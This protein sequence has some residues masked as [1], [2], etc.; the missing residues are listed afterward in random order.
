[1]RDFDTT[2]DRLECPHAGS[3]DYYDPMWSITAATQ[4]DKLS[5]DVECNNCHGADHLMFDV[6]NDDCSGRTEFDVGDEFTVNSSLRGPRRT[7]KGDTGKITAIADNPLYSGEK[8]VLG[9]VF[10]V[11]G[12]APYPAHLFSLDNFEKL[13]GDSISFK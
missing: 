1:M 11:D 6:G 7:V 9:V 2:Y 4:E 10:G 8:V 3:C 5:L 12:S 13:V